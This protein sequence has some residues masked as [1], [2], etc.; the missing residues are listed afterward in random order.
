MSDK[1]LVL[2]ERFV[3][4]LPAF[5]L[6]DKTRLLIGLSF[7][8]VA[9][10]SAFA[11]LA[12]RLQGPLRILIHVFAVFLMVPPI[13]GLI[14]SLWMGEESNRRSHHTQAMYKNDIQ[15]FKKVLYAQWICIPP[16][17]AEIAFLFVTRQGCL[18][19]VLPHSPARCECMLTHHFWIFV[20]KMFL[21]PDLCTVIFPAGSVVGSVSSVV[22]GSNFEFGMC[23]IYGFSH[24]LFFFFFFPG[25]S[26]SLSAPPKLPPAM[27]KYANSLAH[28]AQY[29]AQQVGG[30]PSPCFAHRFF[31]AF[32]FGY[33]VA[34]FANYAYGQVLCFDLGT[35]PPTMPWETRIL[36]KGMSSG[37]G[38]IGAAK[39]ADKGG[40]DKG[41]RGGG[42][43]KPAAAA[44]A[45]APA[46]AAARA[47]APAAKRASAPAPRR[48]AAPAPP[49]GGGERVQAIADYTAEEA[50]DLSFREGDRISVT[51][52][53]ESGWWSGK[54]LRTGR[55]GNFPSTYVE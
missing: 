51:T 49:R 30:V 40:G 1:L 32:F 25:I 6:D 54:N 26:P 16:A 55:T 22:A 8:A 27:A 36:P 18:E 42:D 4:A 47:P 12:Y 45:P 37:L 34:C 9:P 19:S 41:G 11:T 10:L 3:D 5:L 52:K 39:K 35:E 29:N 21:V 13:V 17:V 2:Y 46:P 53:F 20:L 28:R 24:S 33:L 15:L 23:D 38:K 31:P 44:A 43:K 7:Q 48:A 50:Q 14:V